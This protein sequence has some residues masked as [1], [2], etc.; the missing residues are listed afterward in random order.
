MNMKMWMDKLYQWI[1]EY[2]PRIA[3]AIILLLI[4]LWVIRLIRKW[5]H[6]RFLKRRVDS[7]FRPFIVSLVSTVLYIFLG[8]AVLQTVGM[9]MTIF[10]ALIGAIGVAAGLALSGTMQNFT[11]GILILVLRPFEIGDTIIA[12]G[13]TGEVTAIKIFYTEIITADN[14]TVIIPNSK[15]SNELIVNLNRTG[16]RRID[17]EMKL[18]FGQDPVKLENIVK[19]VFRSVPEISKLPEPKMEITSMEADGYKVM[20]NGW[21]KS[22]HFNEYKSVVQQLLI[23]RLKAEGFKL[24]GMA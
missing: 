21:V 13:Q 20:M 1:L 3:L 16:T 18:N 5:F 17:I 4:G 19:D 2:G 23:D 12:Q 9:R 7:N 8:L 14:R 15:L 6:N 10:A 22:E 11:S 24:P